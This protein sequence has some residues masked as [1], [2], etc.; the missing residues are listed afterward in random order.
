MRGTDPLAEIETIGN[1]ESC[2][3]KN[4]SH[5]IRGLATPY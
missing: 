4:I 3:T 2:T 1:C 5:K